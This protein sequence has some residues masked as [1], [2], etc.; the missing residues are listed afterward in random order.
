M[1]RSQKEM[2]I[3]VSSLNFHHIK[4]GPQIADLIPQDAHKYVLS[5][6]SESLILIQ[7]SFFSLCLYYWN[8]RKPREKNLQIFYF[9]CNIFRV[10]TYILAMLSF[11]KHKLLYDKTL[12]TLLNSMTSG[13]KYAL[14]HMKRK[15]ILLSGIC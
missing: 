14:N 8:M 3:Q 7:R 10:L 9:F 15:V 1:A 4:L 2:L 12:Q 6:I 5:V 13:Q 11:G